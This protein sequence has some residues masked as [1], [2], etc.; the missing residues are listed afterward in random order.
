MT[1]ALHLRRGGTSVV[2]RLDGDRLPAIVHWGP[3]LGDGADLGDLLPAVIPPTMDSVVMMPEGVSVL[4]QHSAGW[5]GR[6]GLLGSR[7]GRAWST[8]FTS[9]EHVVSDDDG[10]AVLCSTGQD[11]ES[12]LEVAVELRLTP[13]GLVRVRAGVR[14]LAD[15]CYTV[16]G[17]EPALPVPDEAAE[18]LDMTGRHNHERVPQRR[19]FDTGHWTREAWGGRPGH[20]FPTVLCAGRPGFGFRSGRVWGVHL[21]YSGNQTLRA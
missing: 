9:V 16:D 20:D 10:V 11:P 21:A 5:I 8:A 12:R 4:P 3:D 13:E 18:L 2:V 14:N 15:E 6:P 17:L 7:D 1:E 19:P